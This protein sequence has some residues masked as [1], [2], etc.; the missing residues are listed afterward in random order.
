MSAQGELRR[1]PFTAAVAEALAYAAQVLHDQAEFLRDSKA[2]GDLGERF[3]VDL[4]KCER[5]IDFITR[6]VA[7]K[8]APG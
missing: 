7:T 6:L 1:P 4:A 8:D 2:T 3:R 5:S